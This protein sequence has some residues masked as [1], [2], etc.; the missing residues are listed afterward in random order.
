MKKKRKQNTVGSTHMFT[1]LLSTLYKITAKFQ[2]MFVIFAVF[3]H[4][5]LLTVRFLAE[6]WLGNTALAY[7][8]DHSGTCHEFPTEPHTFVSRLLST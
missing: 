2:G 8:L 1:P 4:C 5:Y 7:G 3:Q 6:P